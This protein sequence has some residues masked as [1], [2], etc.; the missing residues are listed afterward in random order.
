VRGLERR[1]DIFV[2]IERKSAIFMVCGVSRSTLPVAFL[3]GS[4][5]QGK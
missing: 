2:L 4:F 3:G 5:G 1:R